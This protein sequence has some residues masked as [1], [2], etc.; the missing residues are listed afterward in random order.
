M[1]EVEDANGW[2]GKPLPDDV[3]E[4]AVRALG[5]VTRRTRSRRRRGRRGRR[6]VAPR[7]RHP[8][9]LP[10]YEMG[11]KVAT[12]AAFGDA[13]VALGARPEVVAIDGEV[14]N[15]TYT[16]KFGEEPTPSAS[17]RCTSPSSR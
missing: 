5:G 14:G 7:E 4:A 6:P 16:E 17:S 13:L 10:K 12:R 15:S 9:T 8:V 2:H 3:A 1:P 11:M